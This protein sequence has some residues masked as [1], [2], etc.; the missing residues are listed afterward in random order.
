MKKYLIDANL[1]KY[2]ALWAGGA[3]EHVVDINDQLTD[4]EIWAYAREHGLTIVTKDTDFSDRMLVSEPPPRV[5]H[6][7]LGNM[8]MRDFHQ[9]LS[10]SWSE[11]CATSEDYKLVHVYKDRIEGIG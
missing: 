1:P 5:I 10:R 9:A 8:K 11:I 4:S 3:C 7:K 6:I 2:F